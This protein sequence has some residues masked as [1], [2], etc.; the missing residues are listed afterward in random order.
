[1]RIIGESRL[2]G[3]GIGLDFTSFIEYRWTAEN[4]YRKVPRLIEKSIETRN[5]NMR[6][7]KTG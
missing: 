4:Y 6:L 5:W 2:Y 7:G 1:M 3:R